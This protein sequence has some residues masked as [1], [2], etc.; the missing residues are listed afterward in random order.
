MTYRKGF[1]VTE[2]C[3]GGAFI[4]NMGHCVVIY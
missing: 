4:Y 3:D 1:A 2:Y